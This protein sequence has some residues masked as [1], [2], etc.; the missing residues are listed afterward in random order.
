MIVREFALWLRCNK[1]YSKSTVDN[2]CRTLRAFD[3]FI[4]I[5]SHKE[6]G[7]EYPHSIQLED[8]EEFSIYNEKGGKKI[9]TI[10]NYLA[11]I[12]MFLKF[13]NHKGLNVL[14]YRRTLFAREPEFKIEAL[15][16]DLTKQLLTFMKNDT[17]KNEM[18]RMRDYAIGLVLVYGGLRVQELC[19]L[20]VEDLGENMQII[21]KGGVRRFIHLRPEHIQVIQLYLF[22]REKRGIKSDYI[23]VSHSPNS[24]GNKIS[25]ASVEEIIRKAGERAWTWKVRPHKLRHT[26]ATQMLEH[27]GDIV[28]IGQILWH[29][30]LRTTQAYLDYNNDKLRNTQNL[31]PLM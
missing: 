20:R 18:V 31:I 4:R 24:L 26:C 9:R 22:L 19:D 6:R 7:V 28:Y 8:I 16:W 29:K 1:W 30:N 10:N 13:C 25:R 12:K 3:D 2:Y 27:G 17:N 15:S 23:F 5:K 21:G 14:D 11:W